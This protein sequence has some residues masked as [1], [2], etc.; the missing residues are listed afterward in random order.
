MTNHVTRFVRQSVCAIVSEIYICFGIQWRYLL[1]TSLRDTIVL[2]RLITCKLY[3][4]E[5]AYIF[6]KVS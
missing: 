2:N 4:Y 5:Q 1:L 6:K 3:I